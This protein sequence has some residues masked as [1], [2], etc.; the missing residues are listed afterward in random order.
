M[1]EVTDIIAFASKIANITED[2]YIDDKLENVIS[3]KLDFCE[4]RT[5]DA[6]IREFDKPE[7][8]EFK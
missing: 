4:K 2:N 8:P 3:R 7:S 5:Y 1:E 6:K